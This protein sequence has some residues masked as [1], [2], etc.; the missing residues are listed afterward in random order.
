LQDAAQPRS[1]N[2]LD[3]G[4]DAAAHPALGAAAAQFDATVIESGVAQ[5]AG[6][7]FGSLRRNHQANTR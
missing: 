3:G 4:F 7:F 6:Q 1:R 2:L 5:D